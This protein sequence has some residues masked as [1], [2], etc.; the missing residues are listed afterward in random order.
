MVTL[1]SI[2]NLNLNWSLIYSCKTNKTQHGNEL[3]FLSNAYIQLKHIGVELWLQI[4]THKGPIF[5]PLISDSP[6]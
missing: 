3:A 6:I 4:H 1:G 5:R 2:P